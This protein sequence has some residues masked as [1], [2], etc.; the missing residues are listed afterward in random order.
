MIAE[1][2]LGL[3]GFMDWS[4]LNARMLKGRLFKHLTR[5]QTLSIYPA[6]PA[7]R[8]EDLEEL[9][10]IPAV[11]DF[12]AQSYRRILLREPDLRS[13]VRFAGFLRFRPFYS[14]R[15][16]LQTLLDSEEYRLL[17]CRQHLD[18]QRQCRSLD[19]LR[20]SLELQ[21]QLLEQQL[22]EQQQQIQCLEQQLQQ[23]QQV[24]EEQKQDRV[25][26][27]AEAEIQQ[28]QRKLD[29]QNQQEQLQKVDS[30]ILTE[31]ED[32][33]KIDDA[34]S[35]VREAYGAI[36]G[37]PALAAELA[38]ACHRLCA[39]VDRIKRDFLRG[40][41]LAGSPEPS[42]PLPRDRAVRAPISKT[43]WS[44]PRG[45]RCRICGGSLA[46]RW[47]RQVVPGR[48]VADYYECSACQ[49]LQ[50][51]YPFWLAEAYATENS[52]LEDN[53][54]SGRF[55]RNFSAY[56]YFVAL[57]RAGLVAERP[58]LL[59]FGGGYGLLTQMLLSGGYEAWQTDPYV[60][61]PFLAG[62]RF[63]PKLEGIAP[64]SFDLI[65]A[66]EVF[67]HLTDPLALLDKLTRLL[68]P[69]G[70][71][72]VSTEIYQPG[73][74]DQNWPY[75]STQQ[76]HVTFWSQAALLYCAGQFG[77]ASMGYFPGDKGFCTLFSRLPP[78]VLKVRL[79]KA[80]ALLGDPD[81]IVQMH[82]AWDF[83]TNG[84][85]QQLKEPLVQ[86]PP[87]KLDNGWLMQRRA[88]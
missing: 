25:R 55:V 87:G 9:L 42:V 40:L 68:K 77:F 3:D 33:L 5:P 84:F 22:F 51:P 43:L 24:I 85:M 67:E 17:L 26:E 57:H 72:M 63:L 8:L 62:R 41:L 36:L 88:S 28:T 10:R 47:S 65:F 52:P 58:A 38:D 34:E 70:T 6:G 30:Q 71:L 73:V 45:A 74:H 11:E 49:A 75:L 20:Q 31:H 61:T 60:T 32:L 54:D 48:Y 46:Y 39:G 66:L 37:R 78:D 83:R 29:Q 2:L 23:Q 64:C 35:L 12:V 1:F 44:G 56:S 50:I 21:R 7:L 76:Q 13:A 82:N 80:L 15:K 59:D 27:A 86:S 69:G 18:V 14:R 4:R 53:P 79:T 81:R 19:Q 16:F